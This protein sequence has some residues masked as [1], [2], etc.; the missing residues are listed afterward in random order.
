VCQIL[1]ESPGQGNHGKREHPFSICIF[2]G[3]VHTFLLTIDALPK[4]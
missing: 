4:K 2:P 3:Y 1:L